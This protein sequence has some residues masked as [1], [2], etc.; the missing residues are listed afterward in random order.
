MVDNEKWNV[1]EILA[2]FN[3]YEQ[4]PNGEETVSSLLHFMNRNSC[5]S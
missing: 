1:V 3:M 5:M 2:G 4:S